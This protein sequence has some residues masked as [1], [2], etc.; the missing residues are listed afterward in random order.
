MTKRSDR[1]DAPDA[2]PDCGGPSR[3][4]TSVTVPALGGTPRT[5]LVTRQCGLETCQ[6]KFPVFKS[7]DHLAQ[8]ERAA[9]TRR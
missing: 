8:E 9:W 5:I 6:L 3:V 4:V 1:G 7:E 2:C